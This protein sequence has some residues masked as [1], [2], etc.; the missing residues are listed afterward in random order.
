LNGDASPQSF[1]LFTYKYHLRG[2]CTLPSQHHSK[3]PELY[4][5]FKSL[6]VP[7][8]G[9]EESVQSMQGGG[10]TNQFTVLLKSQFL[11]GIT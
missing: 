4:L 1:I 10:K 11:V 5:S 6:T 2:G 8:I 3:H 9:T 7:S